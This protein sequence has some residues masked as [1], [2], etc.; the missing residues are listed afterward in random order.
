MSYRLIVFLSSLVLA[1]AFTAVGYHLYWQAEKIAAIELAD[2]SD[3]FHSIYTAQNEVMAR[4]GQALAYILATNTEIQRLLDEGNAAVQAEGG[5][6]GGERAA[7]V[8]ETLYARV[9]HQWGDLHT[10]YEVRH[11]H[12]ILPSGVS[13]LRMGSPSYFGDS[14]LTVH[15]MM[16][17][18]LKDHQP[19]SG[20][21]VG[22]SHAGLIGIASVMLT[23][24]GNDERFV[25]MVE[26]G[27]DTVK[28]IERLDKQ[29]GIGIAVLLNDSRVPSAMRESH[30][31]L[32]HIQNN[33]ILATSR[34]EADDL[35]RSEPFSESTRT[36][37]SRLLPWQNQN[38]QLITFALDD[39]QSQRDTQF[40]PPGTV[41]FWQDITPMI[42][43]REHEH[44]ARSRSIFAAYAITQL[45][46]LVL[47]RLSLREWERRLKQK[48]ATIENLSQR[49]ALLLD[50]AADGICGIDGDGNIT[51]INHAALNM[52]GYQLEEVMGKN[53]HNLFHH[54]NSDKRSGSAENCQF[55]QAL[56]SGKAHQSE[57]WFF[58]RDGSCFPIKMTITPIRG[59][60][61]ENG[62]VIV[63]HDITEQRNRQE[64]LLQLATTDSLTGAS[65]RRHFLDQLDAELSRQ[66]RH[67]G[68]ASLL[69]ADLD[70][71]KRINDAHGHAAGDAVLSHFVHTVRQTVR[72]SDII[73]R[74]GGEEFAI[75]LP[76]VGI[77]G[78]YEL[79]ERLRSIFERTPT[80]TG[81]VLISATVSIGISDLRAE[82][83]TAD[84]PLQRADEALYSAKDAGRNCIKVYDPGWH[85]SNPPKLATMP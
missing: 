22:H 26:V 28:Q 40:E 68:A 13:F 21:E 30:Q 73:G 5:G 44:A 37:H 80:K 7:R 4:R 6:G 20:F 31:P 72:R 63:F 19:R 61:S 62:A 71:F 52:H 70:S 51:F 39:Y 65:N 50:T 27:F 78:A 8:R 64:A 69:M 57:E 32:T 33:F 36:L 54:H 77:T 60:G 75:L 85:R 17:D 82:D 42:Q 76:G 3:K 18:I 41:L 34:P 67:G 16:I 29:L 74:L 35:L 84:A 24:P 83:G 58:R 23:S 55:M 56:S 49:N 81:N 15:P 47:L 46:L 43:R 45:A 38:L 59:N 2:S 1:A 53:L 12:F 25:G 10:Q 48:T 11:L 9:Q 79:A 66:R 14:L